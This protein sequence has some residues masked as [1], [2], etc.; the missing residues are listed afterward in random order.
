MTD[1]QRKHASKRF[2]SRGFPEGGAELVEKIKA[3]ATELFAT[4][5]EAH[6]KHVSSLESDECFKHAKKDEESAVM[7]AVKG[8]SRA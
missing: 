5:H 4:I 2:E 6:T 3:Q 8:V 1:A 7:W